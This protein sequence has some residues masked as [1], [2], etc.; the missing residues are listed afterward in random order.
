MGRKI[1]DEKIMDEPDSN[2][3]KNCKNCENCV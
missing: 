1:M 3:N 2:N